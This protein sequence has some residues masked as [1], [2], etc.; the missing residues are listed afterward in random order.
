[1]TLN[2]KKI[3]EFYSDRALLVLIVLAYFLSCCSP[4]VSQ[5]TCGGDGDCTGA[6]CCSTYGYCGEGPD[7]C[8]TGKKIFGAPIIHATCRGNCRGK[9][10]E[11]LYRLPWQK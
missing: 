1:M 10:L 2:W 7:Y 9:G 11:S 4:V 5:F 3:R 6:Q 8:R